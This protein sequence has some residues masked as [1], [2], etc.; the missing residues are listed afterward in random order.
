MEDEILTLVN[1]IR[2]QCFQY[3]EDFAPGDVR[4]QDFEDREGLGRGMVTIR[5]KVAGF[6]VDVAI[7][8]GF[9]FGNE[10]KAAG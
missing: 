4:Y 6:E 7:G 9:Y 10:I 2:E 1:H 5:R 3:A 8:F